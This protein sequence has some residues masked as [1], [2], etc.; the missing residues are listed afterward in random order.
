MELENGLQAASAGILFVIFELC[1]SGLKQFKDL[2][3]LR[4]PSG[5]QIEAPLEVGVTEQQVSVVVRIRLRTQQGVTAL[6]GEC[7][8]VEELIIEKTLDERVL[9]LLAV[10]LLF[11]LKGLD[12]FPQDLLKPGKLVLKFQ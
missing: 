1:V 7:L 11:S 6:W 8:W 10:L 5:N 4:L 12:A 9:E 2:L 3:A